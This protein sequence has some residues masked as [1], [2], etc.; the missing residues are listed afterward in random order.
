[1]SVRKAVSEITTKRTAAYETVNPRKLQNPVT[2]MNI[3][4]KAVQ[5]YAVVRKTVPLC[6]ALNNHIIQI[7]RITADNEITAY[8][9]S[10]TDR[11]AGHITYGDGVGV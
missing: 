1:M 7:I 11:N 9:S 6:L 4:R 2:V 8:N 3:G 10:Q 5:G